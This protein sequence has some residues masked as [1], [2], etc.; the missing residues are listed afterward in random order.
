MWAT[1]VLLGASAVFENQSQAKGPIDPAAPPVRM[2]ALS[3]AGSACPPGSV[4][5]VL[6][7]DEQTLSVVFDRFSSQVGSGTGVD[8]QRLDCTLSIPL[9]LPTGYALSVFSMDVRG[10]ASLVKGARAVVRSSHE[11]TRRNGKLKLDF[12]RDALKGPYEGDFFYEQTLAKR[13]DSDCG[14]FATINVKLELLLDSDGRLRDPVDNKKKQR[15]PDQSLASLDSID[16]TAAPLSYKIQ[17]SRCK[18]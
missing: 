5:A 8:Q 16:T 15:V 18:P 6:S 13:W 7:P 2:G 10:F 4:S 17:L 3:Y 1:L 9:T 12:D 11:F 14:D